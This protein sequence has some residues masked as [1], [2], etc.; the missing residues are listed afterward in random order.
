[1]KN[2]SSEEQLQANT[3]PTPVVAT[4]NSDTVLLSG[5][6]FLISQLKM[7]AEQ[8]RMERFGNGLLAVKGT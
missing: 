5:L 6:H 1:M 8:A 2:F 7:K 3:S 4:Q